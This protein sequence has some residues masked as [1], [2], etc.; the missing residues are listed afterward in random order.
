[1]PFTALQHLQLV[2]CYIVDRY[3]TGL[4]MP[5]TALQLF[6]EVLLWFLRL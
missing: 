1:M 4:V 3:V 5:F 6:Y 2:A